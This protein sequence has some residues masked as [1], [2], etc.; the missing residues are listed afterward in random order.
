MHIG[1]DFLMFALLLHCV[2]FVEFSFVSIVF[3]RLESF[4]RLLLSLLA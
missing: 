3:Y 4:P 2:R 1:F